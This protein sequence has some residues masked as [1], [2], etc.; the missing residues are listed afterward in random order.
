MYGIFTYMKTINL[1]QMY[2]NIPCM[3]HMGITY[4]TQRKWFSPHKSTGMSYISVG[5]PKSRNRQEAAE[6]CLCNM[7]IQLTS[8]RKSRQKRKASVSCRL[9]FGRCFGR[10]TDLAYAMR[11]YLNISSYMGCLHPT[12]IQLELGVGTD[13]RAYSKVWRKCMCRLSNGSVTK[14]AFVLRKHKNAQRSN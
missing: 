14:P 7:P 13:R 5:R 2:V 12:S 6:N 3:E 1:S 4:Q 9:Y 11:P 10:V 8:K